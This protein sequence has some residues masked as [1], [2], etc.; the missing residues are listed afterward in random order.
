MKFVIHLYVFHMVEKVSFMMLKFIQEKI[1]MN[2]QL[3]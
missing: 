3:A 2:Y 1:M